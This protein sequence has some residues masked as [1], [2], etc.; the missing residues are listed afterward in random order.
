MSEFGE[1]PTAGT[2][3]ESGI[4]GREAVDYVK[5]KIFRAPRVIPFVSGLLLVAAVTVSI[6]QGSSWLAYWLA[7][8]SSLMM[9]LGLLVDRN[10]AANPNYSKEEWFNRVSPALYIGSAATVI[11]QIFLVAYAAAK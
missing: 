7:T 8:M 6:F 4:T 5:P 9:A 3:I 2:R 10:R 1:I 11:V